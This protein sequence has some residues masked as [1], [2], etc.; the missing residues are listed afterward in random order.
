MGVPSFASVRQT[1]AQRRAQ[2][3]VSFWE[4]TFESGYFLCPLLS[5]S[6]STCSFSFFIFKYPNCFTFYLVMLKALVVSDSPCPN[7]YPAPMTQTG[8]Y[9]LTVEYFLLAWFG[10]DM[11][12]EYVLCG[13]MSCELSALWLVPLVRVLSNMWPYRSVYTIWHILKTELFFFSFFKK[14]NNISFHRTSKCS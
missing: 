2:Y 7:A 4:N 9:L 12:N 13:G 6:S 10:E 5:Y 3:R 1:P 14:S 8:C 11:A